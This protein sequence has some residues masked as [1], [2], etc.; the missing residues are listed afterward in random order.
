MNPKLSIGIPVYN[1]AQ[2]IKA[3]L[4]SIVSQLR[5]GVEIVISDNASEDNTP[6]IIEKFKEQYNQIIYFR[7][8]NNV[9]ADK[10][11]DLCVR[12]SRSKFVWLFADDDIMVHGGIEKI[13]GV[14][15]NHPEVCEI[16][17][18]S[19][20]PFTVLKEDYFCNSGD[21]FF[22][23]IKYRCGGLSSN[24]VNKNIWENT[25]LSGYMGWDW[26]HMAYLI[27]TLSRY[28]AYI[29]KDS[30]KYEIGGEKRRDAN[31]SFRVMLNAAR[32]YQSMRFH[33]Y[34]KETANRGVLTIERSYRTYIPFNYKA[35]GLKVDWNLIKECV[36]LYKNYPAFWLLDLPLLLM[37]GAIF[38]FLRKVY[39]RSSLRTVYHKYKRR[40]NK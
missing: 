22:A 13:L 21:D 25:D 35:G 15:D 11:I 23:I 39:H 4:K 10:N 16:Y 28:P 38:R 14:I 20:K 5:D 26:I 17:A 9:G 40:L 6:Q 31:L 24:I 2:T 37:P 18:D 34:T 1:G 12:R 27:N 36:F 33:G 7:N 29:C 8:N 19:L 30:L 32:L 3:T